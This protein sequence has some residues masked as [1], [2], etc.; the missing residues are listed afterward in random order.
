MHP[1]PNQAMNNIKRK[2]T[3]VLILIVLAKSLVHFVTPQYHC[4]N[5]NYTSN[6]T[7]KANLN[8]LISSFPSM[9]P[10]SGFYNASEGVAPDIVSLVFLCRGDLQLDTCRS[11]ARGLATDILDNCPTEKE[12]FIYGE[13]CMLRFSDKTIFQRLA[14][15]PGLKSTFFFFEKLIYLTINYR[16]N[17]PKI[18]NLLLNSDFGQEL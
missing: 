5:G 17:C 13:F 1:S 18:H 12:A 7:Y 10:E 16:R 15:Y 6:S 9:I 3:I 11:C 2:W 8:A 14:T 4:R